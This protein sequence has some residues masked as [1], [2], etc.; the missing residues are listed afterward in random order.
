MKLKTMM[1]GLTAAAVLAMGVPVLAEEAEVAVEETAEPEIFETE[2]GVLSIKAPTAEWKKMTDEKHW[3]VMTDG[4]DMITVDHLSNGEN[5]PAVE[6]ANDEFGAIYQAFVSTKNEVFAVKGAAVEQ[7]DLKEIMESISTIQI[8][9]FDTKKAV[10]EKK[11]KAEFGLRE[12]G[13]DYYV[14]ASTLNVRLGCSANDTQIGSLVKGDKVFVKGAVTKDGKDIGWMQIT[15]K[16]SDAYVSAE[17]LSE[18][19][20]A[21][22]E[23]TKAPENA[24]T[25]NPPEMPEIRQITVWDADGN[26]N[27]VF[28]DNAVWRDKDGNTYSTEDEFLFI[29]NETGV[30]YAAQEG[31]LS[32]D[33]AKETA[34]EETAAE[35]AEE[36]NVAPA[37][38]PAAEWITFYSQDGE[39]VKVIMTEDVDVFVDEE[40]NRYERIEGI[41]FN[42]TKDDSKWSS[43]KETWEE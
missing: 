31:F 26:V 28:V 43:E 22:A 2:D 38:T 6:V 23:P 30:R 11:E 18:Q 10:E 33:E 35:P 12:I 27:V 1:Y 25:E 16:G 13:K 41:V 8:L 40:G 19:A 24:S 9:K 15:F 17:F 4:D 5:L 21:A 29:C 20:P 37:E 42:R 7:D 32:N 3:F 34:T 14:T 36:E 39:E